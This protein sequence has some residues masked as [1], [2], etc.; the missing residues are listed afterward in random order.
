MKQETSPVLASA[1]SLL[2]PRGSD[3]TL[4]LCP[5]N[6]PIQSPVSPFRSI[7]QPSLL[8]LTKN[9]PSGVTALRRQTGDCQGPRLTPVQTADHR[10]EQRFA[11]NAAPPDRDRSNTAQQ[12]NQITQIPKSPPA[13]RRSKANP[14]ALANWIHPPRR[15]PRFSA[16]RHDTIVPFL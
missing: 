16:S 4:T 14:R 12:A 5:S 3:S 15:N 6:V 10:F 7:G 11:P 8:A 1:P 13:Q 2:S 9:R